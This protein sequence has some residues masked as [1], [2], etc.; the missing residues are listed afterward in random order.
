MVLTVK[1]LTVKI[2]TVMMLMVIMLTIMMLTAMMLTGTMLTLMSEN[3]WISRQSGSMLGQRVTVKGARPLIGHHHHLFCH[4]SVPIGNNQAQNYLTI[5]LDF[6]CTL[7]NFERKC[8][9]AN[10]Q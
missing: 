6:G 9:R 8:F 5:I 7:L 4:T 2:L 3:G 1:M 10:N